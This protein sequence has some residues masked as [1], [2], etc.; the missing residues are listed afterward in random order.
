M[1]MSPKKMMIAAVLAGLMWNRSGLA[2]SG[3][4]PGIYSFTMKTIDGT[5]QALSA[6]KGKAVL[7][8]NTA[9]EC[10]YTPQYA[11]LEEIYRKYRARGF[12]VL[13]FPSNDFLGQEPGTNEEIKKF[14]TTKYN[15]TFPLFAKITVK[16]AGIHPLYGWLTSQPGSS[17]GIS[18]NFNKF[19]IDPTG[20]VVARFG[21]SVA[22]TSPD[23][24]TKLEGILP[25]GK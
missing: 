25:A 7:V 10:G 12:E 15:T 8:V 6:Y 22:P 5:E 23:L 3:E 2:A 11:G 17:G 18:W 1:S 20:K 13:A 21:S 14:C 19:L 4:K 9:S 16:G 24:T